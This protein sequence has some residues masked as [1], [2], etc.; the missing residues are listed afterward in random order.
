MGSWLIR[1]EDG[2]FEPVYRS[3]VDTM[4]FRI[5]ATDGR[6]LGFNGGPEVRDVD[7]LIYELPQEVSDE[8]DRMALRAIHDVGGCPTMQENL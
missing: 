4:L 5:E 7:G 1:G 2:Q 8:V 3:I 6:S